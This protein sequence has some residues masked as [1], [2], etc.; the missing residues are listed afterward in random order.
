MAEVGASF[1]GGVRM[2]S[3]DTLLSETGNCTVTVTWSGATPNVTDM[4]AA[5]VSNENVMD[6]P[7]T[8]GEVGYNQ[9]VQ[10]GNGANIVYATLS[11]AK[12]NSLILGYCLDSEAASELF[13]AGTS[14]LAMTAGAMGD[15]NDTISSYFGEYGFDTGTGSVSPTCGPTVRGALDIFYTAM[16]AWRP[17]SPGPA[18]VTSGSNATGNNTSP[19]TISVG[20]VQAGDWVNYL[21][22]A[23]NGSA[24]IT[25]SDNCNTGGSSDTPITDK[26]ASGNSGW[27]I[28]HFVVGAN[29]APCTVT[30]AW[31]PGLIA[32]IVTWVVRGV[33]GIET[34]PA[35]NDQTGSGGISAGAN[36]IQSNQQTT[37]VHS[38]DLCVGAS[39]DTNTDGLSTSPGTQTVVWR[40]GANYTVSGEY[41][42]ILS[43][44]YKLS[45]TGSPTAEFTL[46][47]GVA[48]PISGIVCYY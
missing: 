29:T 6:L 7:S 43:E 11:P 25:M 4:Y 16:V 20:S 34:V 24:T 23:Q 41:G 33:T 31:S 9:Q 3:A 22:T 1:G 8:T 19:A 32:Q 38:N 2:A 44:F 21:V 45:G 40:A 35:L 15:A 13:S 30:Y 46:N 14:P 48:Y 42:A 39:S 28:G 12:A 27:L 5:V 18:W 36:V 37:T 10:P 26:A 17:P 47:T